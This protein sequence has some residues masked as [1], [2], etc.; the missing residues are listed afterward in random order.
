[1][2]NIARFDPFRDL[3][4]L[5]ER[6]DRLFDD[7]LSRSRG[8]ADD[9]FQGTWAP[10]VDIY[11]DDESIVLE[12]ELPGMD[13]KDIQVNVSDGVLTL[14]GERKFT[15]ETK[16]ENYHRIERAYGTFSRAFTLPQTVDTMKIAATHKDGVLSVRLPKK[17]EAKP[18]SVDVKVA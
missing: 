9:M 1:M 16:E 17:P 5:K 8:G 10:A 18:R 7:T 2:T 4:T 13:K 12:A 14:K 6:M 15:K 3:Q 11:E